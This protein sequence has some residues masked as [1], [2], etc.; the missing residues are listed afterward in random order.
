MNKT[1]AAVAFG[2]IVLT[3]CFT[4]Q[5]FMKD[6]PSVTLSSFDKLPGSWTYLLDG[7]LK[8]AKR[9]NFKPS[10]H[11][12]SLHTFTLSAGDELSSAT[13]RM[14]E[15]V[16]GGKSDGAGNSI[17][18]RLESFNPRFSCA[19][20]MVE[21][22]CTGTSE[23]AL[24]FTVVKDGKRNN[25]TVSSERSADAPAGQMCDKALDASA[26]ATRKAIRDVLERASERIITIAGR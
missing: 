7:S 6:A 3:G 8:E 13:R 19:V 12:C 25:F 21:G 1:I 23:I 2:T 18:A 20:G 4:P 22:T 9:A 15:D 10:G 5:S 17:S 16:T 14:L 24:G 26:E 11:V